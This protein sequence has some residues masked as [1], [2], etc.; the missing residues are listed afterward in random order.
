[1]VA[2]GGVCRR[3]ANKKKLCFVFSFSFTAGHI[4]EVKRA[5]QFV[6]PPKVEFLLYVKQFLTDISVT[7]ALHE[8]LKSLDPDNLSIFGPDGSPPNS[9][10]AFSAISWGVI[11][12]FW[13][14]CL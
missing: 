3:L 5:L 13:Q 6:R 10:Y 8:K 1:M 11:C 2:S 7:V 12:F 14:I 4:Q 9:R